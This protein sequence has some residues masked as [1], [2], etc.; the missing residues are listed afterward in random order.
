[1][2]E[3]LIKYI[4]DKNDFFKVESLPMNISLNEIIKLQKENPF[5]I[6]YVV[7]GVK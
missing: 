7:K 4:N 5:D 3:I 1:M 6:D 2:R